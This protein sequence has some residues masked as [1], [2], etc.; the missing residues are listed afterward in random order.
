MEVKGGE[1]RQGGR[2]KGEAKIRGGP[3]KREQGRAFKEGGGTQE[4]EDGKLG[5]KGEAEGAIERAL[6]QTC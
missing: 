1:N 6:P 4:E 2:E 3:H 5:K